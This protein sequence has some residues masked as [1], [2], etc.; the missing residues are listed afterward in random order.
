LKEY[1]PVVVTLWYRS[2]ELLLNTKKYSTAVDMWSIGCIFGEILLM[3]ALFP[4]KNEKEQ[5]D[6]IFK[7]LGT[8]NDKIWPEFKELPLAKKLNFPEFPYNT[9]RSRFGSYLSDKGFELINKLLTYAPEKRITAEESL[10]H[11][12]FKETPLPVDVSLFPTWPAKSEGSSLKNKVPQ[13]SEPR[14]PSPG[15]MFEKLLGEDDGFTLHANP[16]KTGFTLKF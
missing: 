3:K 16:I 1:T 15:K 12:F 2:P 4:G 6:K 7:D 10:K 14:A 13:D 8:P 9:L 5:L 11:E